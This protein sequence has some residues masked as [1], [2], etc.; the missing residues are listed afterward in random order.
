ME[1]QI[2]EM[3]P[4]ERLYCYSQSTQIEGQTGCIG[5]L[6]ADMDSDGK[7]FFSSWTGHRRD[8]KTQAFKDEF[9]EVL[10]AFRFDSSYDGILKDRN[11]L[12][13]YCHS[14]PEASVGN[15]QEWGFR[16]DTPSHTYIL[17][18]NPHKGEYNLYCYCFQRV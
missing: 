6:R 7:G 2:R 18:L 4:Q 16:A 10:V 17:R 12:S 8:L 13:R 1:L 3:M 15:E 5:H 9:D 11:C 14:H